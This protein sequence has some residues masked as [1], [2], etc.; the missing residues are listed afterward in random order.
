[1]QKMWPAWYTP[2]S[3]WN[4]RI[5]KVTSVCHVNTTSFQSLMNN[6]GKQCSIFAYEFRDRA[7]RATSQVSE[8]YLAP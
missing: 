8:E 3:P 5:R 6:R 1:M 7:A 2:G 4:G